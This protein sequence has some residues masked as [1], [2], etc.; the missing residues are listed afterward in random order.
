MLIRLGLGKFQCDAKLL[1][2]LVPL[3]FGDQAE[4]AGVQAFK[5][6]FGIARDQLLGFLEQA[7]RL[8][9]FRAPASKARERMKCL[10]LAECVLL[11]MKEF[12]RTVEQARRFTGLTLQPRDLS[13]MQ[14]RTWETLEEFI[15]HLVG[16]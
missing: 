12:D 10:S 8:G 16:K 3:S 7:D 4:A 1:L 14:Q 6:C 13:L 11:S 2:S 9:R 5:I 15:R